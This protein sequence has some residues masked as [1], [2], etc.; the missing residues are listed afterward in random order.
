MNPPPSEVTQLLKAWRRGDEQALEQLT[1]VVESELRRIAR[2]QLRKESPGQTLQP[3][4]LMNE[5][6]L[7]LFEWNSVEWQD[8]T[9]FFAV[10]AKIMRRV[11]GKE[12]SHRQAQTQTR[13]AVYR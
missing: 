8:R 12:S 11:L 4:A 6:Y 1:H 5:V 9:D 2:A 3:T 10:A 13:T 7:R